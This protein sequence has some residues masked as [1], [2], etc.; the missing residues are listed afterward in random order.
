MYDSLKILGLGFG[1]TEA[2]LKHSFRRLSIV[3]H[4]DKH[5]PEETGLSFAMSSGQVHIELEFFGG[6]NSSQQ[7]K[8]QAARRAQRTIL[9]IGIGPLFSFFKAVI[10]F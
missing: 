2:E 3:Y 4:P 9:Q 7:E 6:K 8:N 5:K 1:A 10:D